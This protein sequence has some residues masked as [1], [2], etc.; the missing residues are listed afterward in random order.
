MISHTN[1]LAVSEKGRTPTTKK[2]WCLYKKMVFV[3]MMFMVFVV[4]GHPQ[5]NTDQIG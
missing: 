4:L 1:V 5:V 3:W 2:H